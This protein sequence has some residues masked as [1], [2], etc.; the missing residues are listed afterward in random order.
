MK[1]SQFTFTLVVYSASFSLLAQDNPAYPPSCGNFGMSYEYKVKKFLRL[2]PNIRTAE[3]N[4]V[5]TPDNGIPD[6]GRDSHDILSGLAA[7]ETL[8]G[9]SSTL[10]SDALINESTDGPVS[11]VVPF[12]FR[13]A[14][15]D[16]EDFKLRDFR[17]ELPRVYDPDSPDDR[18]L[19]RSGGMNLGAVNYRCVV[20]IEPVVE[21][22]QLAY[23]QG[24][25]D[26]A[27]TLHTY[28]DLQT[29]VDEDGDG[30]G[31][32][33]S[34][35]CLAEPVDLRVCIDSDGDGWGWDGSA[36]CIP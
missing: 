10:Y 34:G 30:W 14:H 2:Y 23:I 28:V 8:G 25:I 22:W 5:L 15:V 31:W 6:E 24:Y 21:G 9:Y 36:T 12:W 3:V 35:S 16:D 7:P 18:S 13:D 26:R 11:V 27:T 17:G 29:C 32:N 19:V 20:K 33:N 4:V 1:Y